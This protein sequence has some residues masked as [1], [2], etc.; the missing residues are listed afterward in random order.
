MTYH[1]NIINKETFEIEH[2]SETKKVNDGFGIMEQFQGYDGEI[3]AEYWARDEMKLFSLTE[4]THKIT[5]VGVLFHIKKII[6]DEYEGSDVSNTK[7]K[8]L[9]LGDFD[10]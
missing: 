4:D 5:L 8:R 9:R 1:Y 10:Y 3:E 7:R 2:T 6:P